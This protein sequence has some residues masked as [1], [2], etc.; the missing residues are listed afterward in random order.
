MNSS[1]PEPRNPGPL[2]LN[3]KCSSPDSK[4]EFSQ[5][6]QDFKLKFGEERYVYGSSPH[7]PSPR[8][9]FRETV[10]AT[11]KLLAM[12]KLVQCM[13]VQIFVQGL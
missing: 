4:L 2:V 11:P 1:E 7:I 8:Q 6:L 13:F 5:T 10:P 3:R 9:L 12:A